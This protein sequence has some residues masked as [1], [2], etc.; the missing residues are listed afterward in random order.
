MKF[1]IL[2]IVFF[3][4]LSAVQA[5]ELSYF[6]EHAFQHHPQLKSAEAEIKAAESTETG[7]TWLQDPDLSVGYNLLSGGMQDWS[8]GIHQNFD[9]FGTTK[10]EKKQSRLRTHQKEIDLNRLKKQ[11]EIEVSSEYYELQRIINSI[12]VQKEIIRNYKDL[13]SLSTNN[14]AV[15]KGTMSDV[16]RVE[17]ERKKA[18]AE[19]KKLRLEWKKKASGFNRSIRRNPADSIEIHQVSYLKHRSFSDETAHPELEKLKLQ[20]EENELIESS[21][22]KGSLPKIGVG[23]EYIKM[24]PSGEEL[25]P[26]LSFSLPIF[27]KKYNAQKKT[28]ELEREAL[29]YEKQAKQIEVDTKRENLFNEVAQT[30]LEL[31]LIDEQVKAIENAKELLIA[32]YSTSGN[33]FKEDLEIEREEAQYK[34]ER[35]RLETELLTRIK[36]LEYYN[37]TGN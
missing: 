18:E 16:I 23:V 25:M 30:E 1:R 6:V 9:W 13:E 37:R 34:L 17:M 11:V 10:I 14:L 2:V 8:V 28:N 33:D 3:G 7:I 32:Y 20:I 24:K 12:E 29:E 22:H 27:R 5:Q 15:S 21:I 31:E 36:S 4:W 19:L 26:M 35:I